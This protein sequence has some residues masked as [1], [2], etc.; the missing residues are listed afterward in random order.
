MKSLFQKNTILNLLA[1]LGIVLFF[2]EFYR[3]LL[4]LTNSRS[5]PNF[6]FF[7][8][9]VGIWFDIITVALYYLPFIALTLLPL[10]RMVEKIRSIVLIIFFSLTSFLV[11]L[12]NAMDV[13]YFSYVNKRTSFDY[14]VYMLSNDETSNLAGDFIL[15]F[16]W[17]LSFFFISFIGTIYLYRK[18]KTIEIDFRSKTSY[19]TLLAA[20]LLTVLIGRGGFQLKPV[21]ILES[22]NYCSL[23]NSPAVLNSAFT[24]IKTFDYEGVEKKEYFSES[25]LNSYFNP[26]QITRPQ[27]ILNDSTNVVFV[28]FESFGSM[29]VGPNNAE[30][31]SPYLDSILAQSMYFDEAI[32]N[33]RTSMDAIPTVVSSIPTWMNESF[34]LSS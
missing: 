19:F 12:F 10:P 29:Y 25:E 31:Y 32:A 22:T 5:F 8:H 1:K 6:G 15:E 16:W 2:L 4:L 14:L 23:E 20:L 11:Y 24:I 34:I 7:E 3:I 28:L 17:L 30:S 9:L 18:L 13:A 21:G 33:C 27:E 26:V